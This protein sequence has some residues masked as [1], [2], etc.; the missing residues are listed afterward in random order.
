MVDTFARATL[1][2]VVPLQLF[3]LLGDPHHYVLVYFLIS[4]F[5]LV[6]SMCAFPDPQNLSPRDPGPWHVLHD[7]G[8]VSIVRARPLLVRSR[9]GAAIVRQCHDGD[10]AQPVCLEK[11][12]ARRNFTV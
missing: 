2:V 8:G 9:F 12:P 1:V 11:C 6:A 5:A 10:F 4:C 7:G 3:A